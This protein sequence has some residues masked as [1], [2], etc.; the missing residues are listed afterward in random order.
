MDRNPGCHLALVFTALGALLP[1]Q[2]A[3]RTASP[4]GPSPQLRLRY[5]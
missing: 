5:A 1:A 2:A 3:V 4:S